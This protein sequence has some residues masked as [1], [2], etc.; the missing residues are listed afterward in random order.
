MDEYTVEQIIAKRG[1]KRFKGLY[2]R[3]KWLNCKENTWEPVCNFI[4]LKTKTINN[5][6]L[7][8]LKDYKETAIYFPLLKRKCIT[9]NRRVSKNE[10]FCWNKICKK[11]KTVVENNLK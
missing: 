7:E 2:F 10:I 8:I 1:S 11:I 6:M 3:V 5:I 4:C 9:C